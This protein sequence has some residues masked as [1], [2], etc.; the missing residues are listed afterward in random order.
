MANILTQEN[1]TFGDVL[2]KPSYSEVI[3]RSKVDISVEIENF[4]FKHPFIPANMMS[5]MSYEMCEEIVKIEGL[6]LTHRFSTIEEQ[7]DIFKKLQINFPNWNKFIGCSVGVQD[8]DKLNCKKFYD[9]GVRI[10]CIDIAHGHS[11]MCGD[12]CNYI[13]TN[14][15]DVLLIAGNIATEHGAMFLWNNGADIVKCGIGPSSICST[16]LKAGCGIPQ[17]SALDA[18]DL[19]RNSNLPF[20]SKYKNKKVISDGGIRNVGDCVK[21]LAFSDMIMMGNAFA[22]AKETPGEIMKIDGVKYKKYA[23]SSTHKTTH[24]EGVVALVHTKEKYSDIVEEY[25]QGLKSGCSYTGANNLT[26]LKEK[27]CFVK[28]TNASRAESEIHDVKVIG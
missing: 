3:S 23:G 4:K 6:G 10:F 5:I 2:L 17:L 8:Q 11:K 9:L 16:R 19:I 12:M 28:I 15:K 27:A 7:L 1:L 14:F 18:I 21:A 25:S 22:G 24:I 13:K 20:Y 26:E